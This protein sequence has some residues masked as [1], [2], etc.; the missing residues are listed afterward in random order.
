MPGRQR[1]HDLAQVGDQGVEVIGIARERVG[2]GLQID[3][4]GRQ[5]RRGRVHILATAGRPLTERVDHDGELVANL[6]VERVQDL[7][8]L[9]GGQGVVLG[10]RPAVRDR[11]LR[12]T[13][14]IELDVRFS[15]Q[16]LQSNHGPSVLEDG[17][18]VVVQHHGDPG[19]AC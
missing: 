1:L 4:H 6:W 17:R 10:D 12:T 18:E 7:V 5:V 13:A 16:V 11:S 3:G 15:Q 2:Q 9:D 8:D 19:G 14:A